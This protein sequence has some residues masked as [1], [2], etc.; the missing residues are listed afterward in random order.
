MPEASIPNR[1]AHEAK[2]E[3]SFPWPGAFQKPGVDGAAKRVVMRL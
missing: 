3:Q 1:I 2:K